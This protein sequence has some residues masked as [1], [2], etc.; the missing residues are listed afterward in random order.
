MRELNDHLAEADRGGHPVTAEALAMTG[1]P[2]EGADTASGGLPASAVLDHLSAEGPPDFPYIEARFRTASAP[3]AGG[4]LLHV[5]MH[6]AALRRL[7]QTF[8]LHHVW[9]A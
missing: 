5:D 7:S 9:G 1:Q 3:D 6:T 8:G 4:P 2:I